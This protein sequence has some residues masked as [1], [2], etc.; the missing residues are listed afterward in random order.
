MLPIPTQR[1]RNSLP[2]C[3]G[4]GAPG[5]AFQ[6]RRGADP[7]RRAQLLNH[8]DG[9]IKDRAKAILAAEPNSDR[10]RVVAEF[11]DVLQLEG[12]RTRGET[13]FAKHCLQCHTV[14]HVGKA[15]G[16]ELVGVR[17]RER[18]ALLED[19]LNPNAALSPAYVNYVVAT[20]SGQ[21]VT[22]IIVSETASN[23]TLRR[24]EAAED[25]IPRDDIEEIRSTGQSLMPE[26]IEKSLTRQEL[27]DLI[28]YL[29]Q[30]Q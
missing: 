16:P 17:K 29:K 3:R 13:L 15:V 20:K 5:L 30:I 8:P 24:P 4:A 10:R 22:G 2:E 19:L 26:G 12:D 18:V 14:Q 9:K 28:E 21:V 7:A 6:P 23:I 27:A 25:T 11:A 1:L